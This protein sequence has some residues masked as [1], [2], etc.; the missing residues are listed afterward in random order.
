MGREAHPDPAAAL[1][2]AAAA[3]GLIY[4]SIGLGG[5][6]VVGLLAA[7][8]HELVVAVAGL[9]LLGTIAGG[10]VVGAGGANGIARPRR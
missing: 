6:A 1:R 8:P 4:C 9:A 5:G 3:C 2:R 7:F 10:A